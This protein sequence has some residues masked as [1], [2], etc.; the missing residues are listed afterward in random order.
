MKTI[1]CLFMA[2]G[3]LIAAPSPT[4]AQGDDLTWNELAILVG[5]SVV[6]EVSDSEEEVASAQKI[7][8]ALRNRKSASREELTRAELDLEQARERY[9]KAHSN[10]DN[11]RV[12]KLAF[13]CGKTSDQIR[14]MR[15]SGMGWGQIAKQCGAHPSAAGKAK[16]K[17]KGK[18]KAHKK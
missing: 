17:D 18:S 5:E 12:D 9:D 7:L 15:N 11:A 4:T 3:L 8:D 2:A 16:G 10:L 6:Q 13:E 1:A 14:A